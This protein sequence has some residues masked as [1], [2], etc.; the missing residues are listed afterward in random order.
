[1]NCGDITVL[2][3]PGNGLVAV[4]GY[5]IGWK[6]TKRHRLYYSERGGAVPTVRIGA[7]SLSLIRPAVRRKAEGKDT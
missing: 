2:H 7:W 3:V 5:G 6:D 1:M 4:R